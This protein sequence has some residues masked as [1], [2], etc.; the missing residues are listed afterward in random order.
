MSI[1]LALAHHQPLN[2]FFCLNMVG[3]SITLRILSETTKRFT[4]SFG[5]NWL[6]TDLTETK[7]FR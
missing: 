4:Y 5:F 3:S 7:Q 6:F 2:S 1:L